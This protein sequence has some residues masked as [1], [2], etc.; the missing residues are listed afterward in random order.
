MELSAER[1]LRAIKSTTARIDLL[2]EC[3]N[4]EEVRELIEDEITTLRALNYQLEN[5]AVSDEPATDILMDIRTKVAFATLLH[6]LEIRMGD[7][8]NRDRMG[9]SYE[10]CDGRIQEIERT[11]RLIREAQE[12]VFRQ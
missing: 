1:V 12:E 6:N 8:N 9:E 11:S 4:S 2:K 5:R 3:E 7:I 10:M